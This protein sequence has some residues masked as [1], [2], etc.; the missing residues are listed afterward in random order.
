MLVDFYSPSCAPCKLCAPL[1]SWAATEFEGKV[2]VVKV[3][4][5][6]HSAFVNQFTIRGLPTFAMF[7]G[8]E[9]SGFQEGA[10]GKKVLTD[11]IKKHADVE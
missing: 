2:K 9:G 4:T 5:E 6:E 8:G 10:M 11:Y 7:K 1:V 3:D